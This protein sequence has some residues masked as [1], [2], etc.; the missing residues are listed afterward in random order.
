MKSIPLLPYRIK[1]VGYSLLFV[2]LLFLLLLKLE[3]FPEKF[4]NVTVF[5]VY[6]DGE[7][8]YIGE[9]AHLKETHWF[10]LIRDDFA[11]EI[12]ISLLIIGFFFVAFSKEKIEDEF[13]M[14]LRL[15]SLLTAAFMHTILIFLSNLFI[16]GFSFYWALTVNMFLLLLVFVIHF[17]VSIFIQNKKMAHEE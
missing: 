7:V 15:N 3:I 6:G 11:Y 14:R 1:P 9:K 2:G 8:L 10:T 5:Q 4:F 13:I 17:R 12:L 16:Y